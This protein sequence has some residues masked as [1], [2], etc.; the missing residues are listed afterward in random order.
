MAK[1]IRSAANRQEAVKILKCLAE[2]GP[3]INKRGL[4]VT[5]SSDSRGKIVSSKAL[6]TSYGQKAHFMAVANIDKLFF[7]AIEPWEFELNPHKN[8]NDLTARHYLYA[9][10]EFA[11]KL[12]PVKLTVKEYKDTLLNK[13]LYSIEAIDAELGQ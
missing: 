6:K 11:N 1:P 9:P 3:L 5:L 13:R 8:N 10:L 4:I 2:K 7:N 12:I